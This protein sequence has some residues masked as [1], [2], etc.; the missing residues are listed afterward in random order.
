MHNIGMHIWVLS[1]AKPGHFNQSMGLANALLSRIPGDITVIDISGK[2]FFEKLRYVTGL[3]DKEKPD[4]IIG[5]GHA[6]HA[7]LLRAAKYYKVPSIVCMKP[8]L[9][10]FLFSLCVVPRHDLDTDRH[11]SKTNIFPTIG[12]M[13]SIRPNPDAEKKNTLILIGGPSKEYGWNPHM[14]KELLVDYIEPYTEGDIIMTTSRRTPEGFVSMFGEG[15]TRIK[16]VPVEETY[17]GWVAEQLATAR[18]V[19]VTEDSVSMVYEALGSGS[20]VGIIPMPRELSN[21]SRVAY[22]LSML[23][24]EKRAIHLDEWAKTRTFYEQTEPLLE[25]D[26]A[27][28][29]IIQRFPQLS[30]P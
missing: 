24:K 5:A 15:E 17:Q 19:W 4:I 3:T 9:P 2:K 26:R 10:A 20:P 22:G 14:L 28:D 21:K 29:Y 16:I 23:L 11:Y 12:A 25:A 27:A 30:R 7:P 8:S 1:D 13:H 6:T 18:A